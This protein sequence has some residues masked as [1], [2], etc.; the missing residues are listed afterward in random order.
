MRKE[1]KELLNKRVKCE[2][3][4]IS[5]YTEEVPVS[6]RYPKGLCGRATIRNVR[7]AGEE[8]THINVRVPLRNLDKFKQKIGK[9][10]EFT[11]I[12]YKYTK[13]SRDSKGRLTGVYKEDYSINEIKNV[14][15]KGDIKRK[16]NV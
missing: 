1:L 4:I 10:I 8:I 9:H 5:A 6:R 16:E 12:V 2:G 14:S 11:G 3:D 7:V 13:N 15:V